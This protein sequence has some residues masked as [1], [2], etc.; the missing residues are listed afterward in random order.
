[1]N[2]PL[3]NVIDS[4]TGRMKSCQVEFFRKWNEAFRRCLSLPPTFRIEAY[5][6]LCN[7]FKLRKEEYQLMSSELRMF[8]DSRVTSWDGLL[9]LRGYDYYATDPLMNPVAYRG[10]SA[11]LWNSFQRRWHTYPR[12]FTFDFLQTESLSFADWVG[13][14][15]LLEY[16]FSD[17][18]LLQWYLFK[19]E[20]V[21]EQI[22]F[23][24]AEKAKVTVETFLE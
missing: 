20:T 15:E 24:V 17:L 1:M 19:N 12:E 3:F 11:R 2:E 6:D 13:V 22:D 8:F 4:V 5:I 9:F 10:D 7:G 16:L 23:H 14:T 18:T 21:L